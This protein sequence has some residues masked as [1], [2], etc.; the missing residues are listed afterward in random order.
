MKEQGRAPLGLH[1]VLVGYCLRPNEPFFKVRVDGPGS[2]GGRHA[3]R[4]SPGFCLLF[5]CA[6]KQT[7]C[8]NDSARVSD[9]LSPTLAP[10]IFLFPTKKRPKQ[11]TATRKAWISVLIGDALRRWRGDQHDAVRLVSTLTTRLCSRYPTGSA[12]PEDNLRREQAPVVK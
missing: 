2:L 10:L 12:K 4:N 8:R 3:S 1:K 11:I 7:A 6:L 5:S 9:Q